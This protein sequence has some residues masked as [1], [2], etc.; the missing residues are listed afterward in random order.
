MNLAL[1]FEKMK[2]ICNEYG[3]SCD[4]GFIYYRQNNVA[5]YWLN[6]DMKSCTVF[7][8]AIDAYDNVV[9]FTLKLEHFIKLYK[10]T[11][12]ENKLEDIKEDFK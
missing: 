2:E 5:N 11:Q 9:A 7:F 6:N 4:N 1:T 3:F 10:I 8:S 12:M